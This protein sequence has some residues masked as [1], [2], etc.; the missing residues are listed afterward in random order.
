MEEYYQH[1]GRA[2]RDGGPA[3]CTMF[4]SDAD[5]ARYASDFYI[6]NLA[7]TAKQARRV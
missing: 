3:T 7:P 5:F 1:I 6:G 2:G 4:S